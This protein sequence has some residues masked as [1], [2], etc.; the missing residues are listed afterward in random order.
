MQQSCMVPAVE[1]ALFTGL[2][3][4]ILI[5]VNTG[6]TVTGLNY[7]KVQGS[8]A[9]SWTILIWLKPLAFGVNPFRSFGFYR[10]Q[11]NTLNCIYR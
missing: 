2:T 9:E 3:T 1:A 11:T 7:M 4:T 10:E 8:L 5:A 6:S